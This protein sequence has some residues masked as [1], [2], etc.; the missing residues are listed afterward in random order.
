MRGLRIADPH[1]AILNGRI[2]LGRS[3]GR[4]DVQVKYI[5]PSWNTENG[6]S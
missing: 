6:V 4:T 5:A 3:T 2:I 1:I